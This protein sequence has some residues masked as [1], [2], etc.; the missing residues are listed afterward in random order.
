M[1]I[2]DKHYWRRGRFGHLSGRCARGREKARSEAALRDIR[3]LYIKY[4]SFCG[5]I[6]RPPD[7]DDFRDFSRFAINTLLIGADVK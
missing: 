3:K 7:D 6:L 4:L 1:A 5:M 2:A